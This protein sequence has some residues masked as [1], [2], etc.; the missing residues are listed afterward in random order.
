MN[1]EL[2]LDPVSALLTSIGV[3]LLAARQRSSNTPCYFYICSQIWY[4]RM[5]VA[6]QMASRPMILAS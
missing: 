4:K 6:N 1:I 5:L 3:L 2:L